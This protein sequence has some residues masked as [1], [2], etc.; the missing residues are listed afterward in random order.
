MVPQEYSRIPM[1][2]YQKNVLIINGWSI[3]ILNN[4]HWSAGDHK[5][6]IVTMSLDTI[7]DTI[8]LEKLTASEQYQ[9]DKKTKDNLI[10]YHILRESKRWTYN[11][12]QVNGLAWVQKDLENYARFALQFMYWDCNIL[13]FEQ[14][15]SSLWY[16]CNENRIFK[17]QFK[18]NRR[19]E[20][21]NHA[22]LFN[23]ARDPQWKT[24][25]EWE[26]LNELYFYFKICL[27]LTAIILHRRNV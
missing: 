14:V 17:E 26:L 18:R 3:R 19:T 12:A 13:N 6:S 16:K 25:R 10:F 21:S 27:W 4:V 2:N 5:S 24:G 22:S 20:K 11:G 15:N 7:K 8:L 9:E 23:W 1:R